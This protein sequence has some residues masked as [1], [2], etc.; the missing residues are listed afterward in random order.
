MQTRAAT[1]NETLKENNDLL[2]RDMNE[3]F[4]T[5]TEKI[6]TVKRDATVKDNRNDEKMA[7]ILQRLDSIEKNMNTNKDKCE[8]NKK[9][10]EKQRERTKQFKDMVGL[11]DKPEETTRPK[12]WSELV[13][14]SREEEDKRKEKEKEKQ[15]KHWSKQIFVKEKQ[16]DKKDVEEKGEKSKNTKEKDDE[17][18][19]KAKNEKEKENLRLSDKVLHDEADW[20]WEDSDLEWEGTVERTEAQKKRKIERYR[21]KKMFETKVATKAKHM[22]GIGPIRRESIG[23]FFDITADDE[24]AKKMAVDEFLCEYLQLEE[25]ERKYFEI[26]ETAVAKKRR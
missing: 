14:E 11:V 19:K 21:K 18:V 20:S 12:T 2:R 8:E 13:D 24:E 3:R 22:I 1:N 7:G 16:S 6:D 9:E 23:Y 10:R 15:V 26:V 17:V 5:L 4:K 25:D